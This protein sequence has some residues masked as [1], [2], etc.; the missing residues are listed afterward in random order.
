[1]FVM[2]LIVSLLLITLSACGQQSKHSINPRAKKLNDSAV[3]LVVREFNYDKAIEL[4]NEAIKI[5]SNYPTAFVNKINFQLQLKQF[6]KALAT[7]KNLLRIKPNAPDYVVMTGII[8]E[9]LGDTVSSKKYFTQAAKIYDDIL[10]TMDIANKNY[11]MH[12]INKAVNLIF[13]GQQQT[14]NDILKKVY[15]NT[16]D[17]VEKEF[18]SEFMN[19][20]KQQILSDILQGSQH[21]AQ[22]QQSN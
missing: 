11:N 16:K 14:G 12:L 1:M 17:E 15:G 10:D 4:L 6:D 19:K 22:T 3:Y 7:S 13:L 5:D 21:S 9:Q 8:N 20:S 18:I 2:R